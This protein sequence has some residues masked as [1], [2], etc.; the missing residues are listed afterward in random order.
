MTKPWDHPDVERMGT[1]PVIYVAAGSHASYPEA[2]HYPLMALYNLI[3]YATGETLTVDYDDWRS[4]IN[5]ERAPWLSTYLG[6]WGTRYWLPLAWMRKTLGELAPKVS[7]EVYL[8]GVSAPRGPKF[9]D[10]GEERETWAD[11]VTFAGIA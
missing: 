3:D 11:P 4:R 9:S 10:D 1:H 7:G 2:K 8:P 5:L 6:S